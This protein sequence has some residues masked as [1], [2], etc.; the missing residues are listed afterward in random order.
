MTKAIFKLAMVWF[1]SAMIISLA[2]C[3]TADSAQ[4]GKQASVTVPAQSEADI[5]K[6]VTKAFEAHDY[7]ALGGLA[8]EKKGTLWET[9]HYGGMSQEPVWI[10][11]RVS[12]EPAEDGQ[13]VIACNAFAVDAH[14]QNGTETEHKL[15]VTRRA[16]CK[17]ILAEAQ[18]A[19]ASPAAA[20]PESP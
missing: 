18:A 10:R 14:G 19:L 4:S 7:T 3:A 16:E 12:L 8:F 1:L 15:T 20:P 9:A 6:A 5:K 13:Y 17:K 11:V 2:G